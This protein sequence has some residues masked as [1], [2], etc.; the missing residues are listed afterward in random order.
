ML[1]GQHVGARRRRGGGGEGALGVREKGGR[2]ND[3]QS[4]SALRAECFMATP[5]V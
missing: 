1:R 3:G 2:E 5:W 4:M